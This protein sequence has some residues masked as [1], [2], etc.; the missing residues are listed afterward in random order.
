MSDM[1]ESAGNGRCALEHAALTD[2]GLRRSNNQDCLAVALA[3]DDQDWHRRGHLFMVADGMG[4]H[5]AG[6]LASKMA[7]ESI[8]HT[9]HK[10]ISH[11]PAESVRQAVA[12]ANET[13][14]ERG[15]ANAEFQGM[16]TTCSVLVLLPASAIVA[17]VGDSR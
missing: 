11:S 15:Q 4:A 7:C 5:A 6:E 17:H 14:H 9:Y 16:G 1:A 12:T 2:V 3:G 10:L 8:P 13:I